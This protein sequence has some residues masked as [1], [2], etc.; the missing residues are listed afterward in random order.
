VFL[1]CAKE[2]HM[3]SFSGSEAAS[4]WCSSEGLNVD[5][6]Q[7]L[8]EKTY[9]GRCCKECVEVD[10]YHIPGFRQRRTKDS[11]NKLALTRR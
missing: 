8:R 5:D 7:R 4:Q 1:A 10:S 11:D 2:G 6:S 3:V 9:G